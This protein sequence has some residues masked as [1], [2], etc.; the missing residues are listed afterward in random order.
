VGGGG[1]ERERQKVLQYAQRT[2]FVR[3]KVLLENVLSEKNQLELLTTVRRLLFP[4][5]AITY[6]YKNQVTQVVLEIDLS[7]KDAGFNLKFQFEWGLNQH[8]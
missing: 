5:M 6:D 7:N 2:T 3:N 4:L 8:D 1:R